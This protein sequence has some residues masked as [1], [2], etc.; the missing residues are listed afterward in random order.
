MNK[1]LQLLIGLVLVLV[2]IWTA[3]TFPGWGQ[4]VI[5]LIQGG[6]VIGVAL[7]GLVLIVLGISSMKDND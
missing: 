7:I 3:I 6:L 4:A 1:W 2:P 5:D